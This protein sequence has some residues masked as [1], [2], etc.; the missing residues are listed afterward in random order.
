MF[1]FLMI[2]STLHITIC[3]ILTIFVLISPSKAQKNISSVEDLWKYAND[4]NIQIKT[5]FNEKY[6]AEYTKKQAYSK[7]FPSIYLSGSMTDNITIQPTLVPATLFNS[8][9]NPENY[10]EVKFGKRYNYNGNISAQ[11]EIFNANNLYNIKYA[12]ISRNI[13]N[14][15]IKQQKKYIYTQISSGY[16]TAIMLEEKSKIFIQNMYNYQELYKISQNQYA[17]GTI[18][19]ITLNNVLITQQKIENSF[20]LISYQK[21]ENYHNLKVLLNTED[22]IIIPL[23]FLH[24]SLDST[25]QYSP[26][27]QPEELISEQQYL[28]QHTQLQGAKAAFYPTV[29]INYQ[30]TNQIVENDLLAFSNTNKIPQQFWNIKM[31]IPVFQGNSRRYEIQKNKVLEQSKWQMYEAVQKQQKLYFKSNYAAYRSAIQ[32]FRSSQQ[33]MALAQKNDTHAQQKLQEGIIA[34]DERLR[35][36]NDLLLYQADYIEAL[37]NLLIQEVNLK[38]QQQNFD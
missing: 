4:N 14:T 32:A 23:Q 6:A 10:T 28:M 11:W 25:S 24:Y 8:A 26:K 29:S 15:N 2:R 36:Y 17:Q 27:A 38:I 31:S 19:E 1:S 16:I 30:Y 9:A 35:Y 7:L 5:A 37:Q 21:I 3:G 13:G 33:I 22:S 18:S 20:N 12:S 34:L